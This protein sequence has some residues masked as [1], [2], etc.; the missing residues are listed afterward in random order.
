M[1]DAAWVAAGM[2]VVW[3]GWLWRG[4]PGMALALLAVVTVGAVVYDRR[5]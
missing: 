5:T 2:V 4:E 3:M 1:K